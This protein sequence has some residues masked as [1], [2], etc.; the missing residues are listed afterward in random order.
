MDS[1]SRAKAN[2]RPSKCGPGDQSAV[3][4]SWHPRRSVVASQRLSGLNAIPPGSSRASSCV[5]ALT[6]QC[7]A[8]FERLL[9]PGL[10]DQDPPHGLGRGGKEVAAGVPVG[11]SHRAVIGSR[12]SEIGSRPA[13]VRP[14]TSDFGP[15]GPTKRKYASC[16]RAVAWSVCPDFSCAS[17]AAANCRSS[18]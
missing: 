1:L 16:T 5:Q 2:V 7:A 17:F 4:Q 10:V 15:A 6:L 3:R 14:L 11:P 13:F 18:S 8:G 12:R 9:V